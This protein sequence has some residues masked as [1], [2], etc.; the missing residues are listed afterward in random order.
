MRRL[1]LQNKFLYIQGQ[2]KKA[3]KQQAP[4]HP[5]DRLKKLDKE[6]KCPR[7]KQLN[8]L[9]TDGKIKKSKLQEDTVVRR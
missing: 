4:I 1:T 3:T 5:R 7:L 2:I 8:I 9:K 6:L